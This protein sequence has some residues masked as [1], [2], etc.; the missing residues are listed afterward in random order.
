MVEL[1]KSYVKVLKW[2]IAVLHL[3]ASFIFNLNLF[4]SQ[5]KKMDTR[6]H[7]NTAPQ[8]HTL[9]RTWLDDQSGV[10]EFSFTILDEEVYF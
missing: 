3:N 7:G 4:T 9:R 6:F 2:I 10:G 1:S 5:I 8:H